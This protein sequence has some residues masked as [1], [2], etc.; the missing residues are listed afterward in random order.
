[1]ERREHV[2]LDTVYRETCNYGLNLQRF[3]LARRLHRATAFQR[4]S[5]RVPCNIRYGLRRY[6]TDTT[7]TKDIR[8]ADGCG[9][10]WIW[11]LNVSLQKIEINLVEV[12]GCEK[13]IL[14][15]LCCFYASS[16]FF[17]FFVHS[18]SSRFNT[19]S[20]WNSTNLRK[21]IIKIYSPTVIIRKIE[22][23][24]N[25]YACNSLFPPFFSWFNHFGRVQNFKNTP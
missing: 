11:K 22:A 4:V 14:R 1:M 15:N 10:P 7:E 18:S 17:F 21:F 8:K 20:K 16:F 6:R 9:I 3:S 19:R 24:L 25:I 12:G 5:T 2:A 23:H 13:R